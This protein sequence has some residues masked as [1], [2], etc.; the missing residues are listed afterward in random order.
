MVIGVG[1]LRLHAGQRDRDYRDFES[2][3]DD[4]GYVAGGELSLFTGKRSTHLNLWV[5][6]AWNLA[7]TLM[8][9]V[10]L[11]RAGAAY[12]VMPSA[13]YDGRGAGRR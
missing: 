6:H 1:S 10:T 3:P 7:R 4:H 12:G 13:E 9:C 2:V 11:F 5:R 8:V